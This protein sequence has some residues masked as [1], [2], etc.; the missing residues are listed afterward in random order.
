MALSLEDCHLQLLG[1]LA[2]L[3]CIEDSIHRVINSEVQKRSWVKNTVLEKK[4][5]CSE[6]M[7]G[8]WW[9]ALLG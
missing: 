8:K 7:V 2:S 4:D 3:L 9:L 1:Q 6:S 5:A